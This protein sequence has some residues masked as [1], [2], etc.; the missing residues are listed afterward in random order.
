[1]ETNKNGQRDQDDLRGTDNS[2]NETLHV[3]KD[4]S[5]N[6][7]ADQGRE[8]RRHHQEFGNR[9]YES[10]KN[11]SSAGDQPMTDTGV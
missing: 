1:M 7:I 5:G 6:D 10:N 2:E 3:D 9:K 8:E 4:V 11:H